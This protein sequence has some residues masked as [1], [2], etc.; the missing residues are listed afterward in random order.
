MTDADKILH[1]LAEMQ[2]DITS[3]QV[4]QQTLQTAV[5]HQGK[6]IA[7][8]QDGQ[9]TLESGQ[10]TLELKVEAFHSEQKTANKGMISVLHEIGEVN[11]QA[12]EKRFTRI[13]K[14]LNLPPVK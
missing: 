5:D 14:H 11:A 13:E 6:A 8:L 1:A 12:A 2:K 3:L 4:G 7:G 9:K 10:K